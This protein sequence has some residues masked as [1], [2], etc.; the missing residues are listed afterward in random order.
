MKRCLSFLFLGSLV[1]TGCQIGGPSSVVMPLEDDEEYRFTNKQLSQEEYSSVLYC[2]KKPNVDCEYKVTLNYNIDDEMFDTTTNGE[3]VKYS[4]AIEGEF[5]SSVSLFTSNI[6]GAFCLGSSYHKYFFEEDDVDHSYETTIQYGTYKG[7]LDYGNLLKHEYV[8]TTDYQ[9]QSYNPNIPT[10]YPS[11]DQQKDVKTPRKDFRAMRNT[12]IFIDE[13]L[14]LNGVSP[15]PVS[16][17]YSNID[18]RFE[19]IPV[20]SHKLDSKHL[21]IEEK[22]QLL[23]S[24]FSTSDLNAV[25][26]IDKMLEQSKCYSITKYYY[27]YKTG[28]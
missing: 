23:E 16:F 13:A 18:Y 8:G 10:Y 1:L 14:S 17:G 26:E 20:Y 6:N 25:R 7:A 21:I 15:F 24:G 27:D 28:N 4:Y 2:L 5:R 12:D 3:Y 9:E 22:R 19:D 11:S